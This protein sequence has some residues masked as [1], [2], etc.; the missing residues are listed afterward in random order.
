MAFDAMSPFGVTWAYL[1]MLMLMALLVVSLVL[2]VVRRTELTSP[3]LLLLIAAAIGAG[4]W[5]FFTVG[6]SVTVPIAQDPEGAVCLID[7]WGDNPDLSVDWGSDCGRAL[8]RHLLISSAPSL[9]MLAVVIAVTA[10]GVRMKRRGP[11]AS[12]AE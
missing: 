2:V 4:L 1:V 10:Q 12:F 11:E 3:W 7:A 5:T 8:R 9:V 6:Q